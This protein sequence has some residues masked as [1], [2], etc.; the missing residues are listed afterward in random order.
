M[1][2]IMLNSFVVLTEITCNFESLTSFS[3]LKKTKLSGPTS[4]F[5][6]VYY[7]CNIIITASLFSLNLTLL[8]RTLLLCDDGK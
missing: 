3:I 6:Q 2:S 7:F 8:S 1:R 4:M 5:F